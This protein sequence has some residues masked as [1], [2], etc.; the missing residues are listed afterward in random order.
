VSEFATLRGDI[1]RHKAVEFHRQGSHIAFLFRSMFKAIAMGL[2]L[3][4]GGWAYLIL[5]GGGFEELQ[6][7]LDRLPDHLRRN[8]ILATFV[9]LYAFSLLRKLVRRFSDLEPGSL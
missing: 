9:G 2:L 5:H 6:R 7:I 3:F 1:L 4:G 8:W